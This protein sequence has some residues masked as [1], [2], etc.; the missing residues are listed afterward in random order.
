[1]KVWLS[2]CCYLRC[3]VLSKVLTVR[4]RMVEV[5]SIL[6]SFPDIGSRKHLRL[7]FQANM[8][9]VISLTPRNQESFK[10]L[11]HEVC[12]RQVMTCH[13]KVVVD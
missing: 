4:I 2:G 7:R 10:C 11:R 13:S 9:D 5:L 12:R 8:F 1:M 6:S 3:H